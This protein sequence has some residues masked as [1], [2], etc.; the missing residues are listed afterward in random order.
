MNL[1]YQKLKQYYNYARN[2]LK[3]KDKHTK[4]VLFEFNEAQTIIE[5]VRAW[6]REHGLLE[7]YLFLKARQKGVSTYWSGDLLH[8]TSTAFNK[9]AAIIGH[10]IEASQNLFD[11]ATRFYNNLPAPIRPKVK[12]SSEKKIHFERL[13]S[14]IKVM[15]A[16]LTGDDIGRSDTINYLLATEVSSWNKQKST[17]ASLLQ[18]VPNVSDSLIVIETTAKGL[19]DD[20]YNR[21]QTIYADPKR[22]E[23]IPNIAWA[24]LKSQFVGIFISWLLDNEYTKKF[25]D[26]A[27]RKEFEKN[28][29]EYEKILMERGATLE[30]LNW[31][32]FMI[33]DY[34]DNDDALF[35]QEYPSTPEEAFLVSGSPVFNPDIVMRK[36][37]DAEQEQYVQGDLIPVYDGTAA[38][39]K[40]LHS[41]RCSY[42][43]L[44]PYMIGV[45]WVESKTGYIKIYDTLDISDTDIYRFASGWDISEGLAQGDRTIGS[46]LDR[47]T[48][49]VSLEWSGHIDPD[50]VGAEQHKI[51]LFLKNKDYICT[52]RNNH[53][54]T[55]IN[56]AYKMRLRQYY[57]EDFEKGYDEGTEKL[58]FKTNAQNKPVIIDDL[59]EYIRDGIFDDPVTDFWS[60][61]STYV[62]DKKGRMNAQGKSEDPEV[63]CYDDRVMSRALAVRCHKW[64]K[65]YKTTEE[66]LEHKKQVETA[67]RRK[68]FKRKK[69]SIADF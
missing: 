32:R 46:Y 60:E 31:R 10:K 63:K 59:N 57:Q 49:R 9:K 58:G 35:R 24:S 37:Q 47:K 30:H 40:Q 16:G 13:D 62:K 1:V 21:W 25:R 67:K 15:T 29:T 6:V 7:R 56:D 48:M 38:Y 54:L 64:M 55:V 39:E 26:K 2:Y 17:M 65:K 45:E 18:T 42:Y 68:I 50:L 51:S 61:C 36:W 43:D 20:Y 69:R 34:F 11:I 4:V 5:K 66:K 33:T 22:I 44:L 28:I 27:E 52:E 8:K 3:V 12:N 53:G 41:N 14:Q 23:I 19:G